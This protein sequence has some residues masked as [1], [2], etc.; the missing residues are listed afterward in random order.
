MY[1]AQGPQWH[2][3]DRQEKT[4]PSGLRHVDGESSWST[5]AYR[6]WVQ[7][8][9]LLLQTLCF[10]S[11]VPLFA[12]WRENSRNEAKIALEELGKGRLQVTEVMLG[13]TTFG[14][15]DFAPE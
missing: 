7:G 13:D 1:E 10:P 2:K 5:S 12:V 4:M 8:Y 3:K 9:R 6:G 11:P 15:E 14:K